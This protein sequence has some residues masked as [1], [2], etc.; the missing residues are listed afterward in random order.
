MK[1]KKTFNDELYLLMKVRLRKNVAFAQQVM[2]DRKN[3]VK[4]KWIV[5][6]N[7]K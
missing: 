1:Y 7:I 5:Q 6:Y 4:I 3:I 2:V